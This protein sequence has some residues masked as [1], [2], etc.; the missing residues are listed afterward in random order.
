MSDSFRE[1]TSVSWFGRLK[2]SAAGILL[3][4]LLLVAMVIGLFWNEGR[5][6]TT[7]R[8][9]AEGAGLVQTVSAD[10][11]D[12]TLEGRLIH[13]TGP[14]V[15]TREPTDDLFGVVAAGIRLERDVEMYQWV[16]RARSD[17]Q[18]KVGGGEEVVTT[19]TYEKEWSSSAIDSGRFKQPEGHA[20]PGMNYRSERFQIP[21]ASLGAFRLEE[22]VLDR[23]GGARKLTLDQE[24]IDAVR[25]SY[26][27]PR[28]L[29][30]TAGGAYMG[31]DPST[32]RI[33]DYRL[34]WQIV[35]LGPVSVIGRQ[36]VDSFSLYQTVAGNRLL[37]VETGAVSAAQMFADAMT[38]NTILTWALR[39]GGLLLLMFG[40]SL[41]MG[42][43]AVVADVI[44]VLGRI[45][46]L[47]TG[48]IAFVLAVLV[49]GMTIAVAWFWYRP[50]LAIGIVVAAL[51][52]AYGISRMG[53]KPGAAGARDVPAG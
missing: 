34:S 14:V 16:E 7:A 11:I 21:E 15:A 40:F 1:V 8:S 37:M 46:R 30:V 25:A 5:A 20:N 27:G 23:I 28:E 39:I 17:G 49:G 31:P 26:R 3:G 33:G 24:M 36:T 50:L 42:P 12:P 18:V 52:I 45:A 43:I 51:A 48:V 9:L 35:P 32:P 2:R 29:H 13:V 53:G 44:P 6:V 10:R 41:I 19:Y 4:L 22:P 47:G 38:G